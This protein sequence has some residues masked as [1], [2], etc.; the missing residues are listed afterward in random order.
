[1]KKSC[2]R[3]PWLMQSW[4][5][6]KCSWPA[7]LNL[8]VRYE[9]GDIE[10]GGEKDSKWQYG[11]KRDRVRTRN[12]RSHCSV[13]TVG[14][15]EKNVEMEVWSVFQNTQA[16][17]QAV[18][19]ASLCACPLFSSPSS[20]RWSSSTMISVATRLFLILSLSGYLLTFFLPLVLLCIVH[21]CQMH[22]ILYMTGRKCQPTARIRSLAANVGAFSWKDQTDKIVVRTPLICC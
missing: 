7:H 1:M 8:F 9:C 6:P 4:W 11:K 10:L 21:K 2:V 19:A 12:N 22:N 18:R 20:L 15:L 13:R 5:G 16:I 3:Y 17:T 14:G